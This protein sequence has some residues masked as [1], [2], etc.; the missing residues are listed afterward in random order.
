M[1][2][3]NQLL[4]DLKYLQNT[5]IIN[6][7]NKF[8]DYQLNFTIK[9]FRILNRIR[10]R[11]IIKD[12]FSFENYIK[13]EINIVIRL[14]SNHD[15]N[16]NFKKLL[17]KIHKNHAPH[18]QM[19]LMDIY[20]D[21]YCRYFEIKEIFISKSKQFSYCIK[22]NWLNETEISFWKKSFKNITIF[23]K[24]KLQ[25]YNKYDDYLINKFYNM[26]LINNISLNY[27]NINNDKKTSFENNYIICKLKNS[28][29]KNI[30]GIIQSFIN[31]YIQSFEGWA[32]F[33]CKE[34]FFPDDPSI[35]D[36]SF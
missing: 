36:G 22:N 27:F 28:N 25:E 16:L 13:Q 3:T 1:I 18:N 11:N 26:C 32:S 35:L 31:Y 24:N 4:S 8:N 15:I 17:Y 14:I 30:I 23:I 21:Y 6:L 12:I 9:K 10:R 33:Y 34:E 7:F 29:M 20:E 5:E 2:Y 19:I